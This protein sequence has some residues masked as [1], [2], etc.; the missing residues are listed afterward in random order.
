LRC[1][2]PV[3]SIVCWQVC[4]IAVSLSTLCS[5]E[6]CQ[7]D[8]ITVPVCDFACL[9]IWRLPVWHASQKMG[10][11]PTCCTAAG[12]NIQL[13]KAF[14]S[15]CKQRGNILTCPLIPQDRHKTS[16]IMTG[17]T[18]LIPTS[19]RHVH[20]GSTR[21]SHFEKRLPGH[22]RPGRRPLHT[23]ACIASGKGF[24]RPLHQQR[25]LVLDAKVDP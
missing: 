7:S 8:S 1:F 2:N 16:I 4:T 23:R 22:H 15:T 20:A 10:C 18:R 13:Y 14:V 25:S 17:R 3:G 24:V 21:T 5:A 9:T 19:H 12:A 6:S 11:C